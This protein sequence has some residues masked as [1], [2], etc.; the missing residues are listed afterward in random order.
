MEG[1]P[2]AVSSERN[3]KGCTVSNWHGKKRT[4]NGEHRDFRT[5]PVQITEDDF[6]IILLSNCGWREAR[7]DFSEAAR[8][9]YY[10]DDV[11]ENKVIG[12]KT[13]YI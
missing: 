1:D 3:G 10:G 8:K 6:D 5:L 12:M 9:A 7:H 2:D 13:G 11:M 4:H